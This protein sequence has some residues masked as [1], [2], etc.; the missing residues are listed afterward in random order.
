MLIRKSHYGFIRNLG[1]ILTMSSNRQSIT[2]WLL[3]LVP[4]LFFQGHGSQ[5]ALVPGIPVHPLHSPSLLSHRALGLATPINPTALIAQI[6]GD[7]GSPDTD[8][9]GG[10]R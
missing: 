7:M 4:W 6:P 9:D 3:S 5:A 2:I 8:S 10:H 1:V